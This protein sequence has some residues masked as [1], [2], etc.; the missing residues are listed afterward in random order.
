MDKTILV[1]EDEFG[2]AEVLQLML[3]IE[4]YRAIVTSNGREALQRIGTAVPDLV[5]ADYM[6]PIMNGAQLGKA[7]RANPATAK[8]VIVIMSAA[9]E[10]EVRREF[11]AYDAFLRKPYRLDELVPLLARLLEPRGE[12]AGDTKFS[13]VDAVRNLLVPPKPAA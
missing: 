11:D 13:L 1:V 4:G 3:E 10:A 8:V 2:T 6:M 9:D 7:L 5:L 12:A